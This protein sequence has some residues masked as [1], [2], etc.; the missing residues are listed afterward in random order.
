MWVQ[1]F[2]YMSVTSR[3]KMMM[4]DPIVNPLMRLPRPGV[5]SSISNEREGPHRTAIEE[6]TLDSDCSNLYE[7]VGWWR[8]VEG[9]KEKG[10]S[11]WG[12]GGSNIALSLNVDGFQPNKRRGART[13]T[14]LTCMVLNL[15]ENLR[16]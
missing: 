14:P 3:L 12:E 11:E 16:H 9:E 4:E 7:S 13:I 2:L 5:V 10:D 8:G 15:P 6:P 1:K